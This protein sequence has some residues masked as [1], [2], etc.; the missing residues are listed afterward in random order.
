MNSL[1]FAAGR[2]DGLK[3]P[4]PNEISDFVPAGC[5]WRTADLWGKGTDRSPNKMPRVHMWVQERTHYVPQGGQTLVW[6]NILKGS[7]TDSHH[8]VEWVAQYLHHWDFTQ[9]LG[10]RL[11][12]ADR[13]TVLPM[14][15]RPDRHNLLTAPWPGH[16]RKDPNL[17]EP[18]IDE[19]LPIA[20]DFRPTLL[21]GVVKYLSNAP[22]AMVPL[23]DVLAAVKKFTE[24]PYYQLF[25]RA[26]YHSTNVWIRNAYAG[27]LADTFGAVPGPIAPVLNYYRRHRRRLEQ[28]GTK[29]LPFHTQLLAA[30]GE[31]GDIHHLTYVQKMLRSYEYLPGGLCCVFPGVINRQV[32]PAGEE[33]RQFDKD[34]DPNLLPAYA[35]DWRLTDKEIAD[36]E[37]YLEEGDKMCKDSFL[38]DYTNTPPYQYGPEISG[39]YT[40]SASPFTDFFTPS[41]TATPRCNYMR[42]T[43]PEAYC[44]AYESHVGNLTEDFH[45]NAP[46]VYLR[47]HSLTTANRVDPACT[48]DGHYQPQFSFSSAYNYPT[49]S[50]SGSE[51]VQGQL[52][53]QFD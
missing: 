53:C 52:N 16:Q 45:N 21:P 32:P 15:H 3:R 47:G 14:D 37:S 28:E 24:A 13:R 33:Y 17:A 38:D 18:L 36:A 43:A 34:H 46:G 27:A 19:Y 29:E 1:K 4:F 11:F 25:A 49:S 7:P 44:A 41:Y 10:L 12:N 22:D 20:L 39:D 50:G 8:V 9:K 2:P 6:Q 40:P 26:R 35:P 42:Q 23:P 5:E 30:L 48:W 31:W 51:F